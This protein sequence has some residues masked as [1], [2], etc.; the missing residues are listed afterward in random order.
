MY[1]IAICDDQ[2]SSIDELKR[3]LKYY[4]EKHDTDI[5]ETPYQNPDGLLQDIEQGMHFDIIFLDIEMPMI[6]GL[7][8][9]RELAA[10]HVD[11]VIIIVS[12]HLQYSIEA[13][14]LKVFRYLLKGCGEEMFERYLTAALKEID[15][16]RE[17]KYMISTVRKKMLI[18]CEDI[19]YCYKESKMSVMV[20]RNETIKERKALNRL[21]ADLLEICDYFV[22]VERG[23]IVNMHYIEKICGNKICLKNGQT[24]PIGSTYDREVKRALN[25]FWRKRK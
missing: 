19:I 2:Q 6:N 17:N 10:M 9:I 11:S 13:I 1:Q 4:R 15:T 25:E 20:T 16:A 7:E 12:A 22:M 23:Y 3:N 24:I 8:V 21:L 14:E 5:L 18:N